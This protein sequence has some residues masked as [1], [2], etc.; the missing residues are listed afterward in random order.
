MTFDLVTEPWITV[1]LPDGSSKSVG[2]REVLR[3]AHDIVAVTDPDPLVEC[4]LI[5]LLV[6]IIVDVNRPETL[7]DLITLLER[8]SFDAASVDAY[9]GT[10][11]ALFDLFH[12]D[13]PFLQS[14]DPMADEREKPFAA[15]VPWIPSGTNPTLFHHASEDALAVSPASAARLLATVPSFMTAGGTGFSP[16]INGAPPWYL[17]V[18]GRSLFETLLLNTW[19]NRISDL[20]PDPIPLGAPTWRRERDASDGS[21]VTSRP[22]YLES[23]TWT[24]RR[25]RLLPGAGGR[26]AMTGG[27]T[28]ISVS[29]MRFAPGDACGFEWRDPQVAYRA[30]KEGYRVLR[31]SEDRSPW[32]DTESFFLATASRR[33]DARAMRPALVDQWVRLVGEAPDLLP[34]DLSATAYALRSDG[35]MKFFEWLRDRLAL[36]RPLV[37]GETFHA[38]LAGALHDAEATSRSL[39]FALARSAPR[40]GGGGAARASQQFALRRFWDSMRPRFDAYGR[41]VAA[42][43]PGDVAARD[44]AAE[45]WRETL[46]LT[47]TRAFDEASDNRRLDAAALQRIVVARAGLRSALARIGAPAPQTRSTAASKGRS[48]SPR[49]TA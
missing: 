6:A 24:P 8:Q 42:L 25:I 27:E 18:H 30:G 38:R 37:V 5:R 22:S 41:A 43:S 19:V 11:R 7:E 10:H 47:A 40:D 21:R 45:A 2:L 26:C 14:R 39:K 9:L 36:V 48:R 46:W 15:L 12:P 4:G 20:D 28:S 44:D 13:T 34:G 1:A 33:D 3:N 35:N 31:A 23:L 16:S 17:V 32:R 29:R 49:V